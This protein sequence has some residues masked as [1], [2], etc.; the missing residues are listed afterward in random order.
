MT[1]GAVAGVEAGAV[2]LAGAA[3][4][5]AAGV[6][7]RACGQGVGDGLDLGGGEG[8]QVA[9]A[10]D[11]A[12]DGGLDLAGG[13]A[14]FAGRAQAAVTAG[15]VA[16]VESRS[17][18]LHAAVLPPHGNLFDGLWQLVHD[19]LHLAGQVARLNAAVLHARFGLVH[20]SMGLVGHGQ[21][22][23][24]EQ[25]RSV[26]IR[27]AGE[28]RGHLVDLL[29]VD[30]GPDG[31]GHFGDQHLV[32][33]IHQ[34]S[35]G[36]VEIARGLQDGIDQHA[37]LQQGQVGIPDTA[38]GAGQRCHR[39]VVNLAGGD[40]YAGILAK[41]HHLVGAG[42]VG[43]QG[44]QGGDDQWITGSRRHSGLDHSRIGGQAVRAP[45]R[46]LEA[47]SRARG[48]GTGEGE[49]ALFVGRGGG[50]LQDRH[51]VGGDFLE[52]GTD[53]IGIDG[54][55]AGR[56][57][58][59]GVV[60][61]GRTAATTAGCQNGQHSDSRQPADQ[62]F[63]HRKDSFRSVGSDRPV[64]LVPVGGADFVR[65]DSP[66]EREQRASPK[67]RLRAFCAARR[68]I[69][70]A[71]CEGVD[72]AHAQRKDQRMSGRRRNYNQKSSHCVGLPPCQE[73]RLTGLLG[74]Y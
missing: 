24:I 47:D 12:V 50:P 11:V 32:A 41:L 38:G 61:G 65:R 56:R 26:Q 68:R 58:Q 69:W 27:V 22:D 8:V 33:A 4:T 16:G 66:V 37:R 42:A 6:A 43:H 70:A 72:C 64:G 44:G 67:S 18:R 25:D 19:R 10:A 2:R 7:A 71:G 45:L 63:E 13:A 30:H 28:R 1:A 40:V 31:V 46:E 62:V 60:R 3:A 15:A 35:G 36:L 34:V 59:V 51:T 9:H 23:V 21:D 54:D 5:A 20:Q 57:C 48:Q 39:I 17:V 29:R 55:A 74:Q 49:A 52:D 14:G 53:D 73:K